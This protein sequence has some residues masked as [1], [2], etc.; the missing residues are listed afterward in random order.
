MIV[1]NG[2]TADGTDLVELVGNVPR[3]VL[4]CVRGLDEGPRVRGQDTTIPGLPG[5]I[6]RNRVADG[7]TIEGEGYVQGLGES[8]AEELADFRAIVEELR[9]LCDPTQDPYLLEVELEDGGVASIM[10]RPLPQQPLWGPGDQPTW[11]ALSI[12]WEAV[13]D[14]WAIDGAS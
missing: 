1:T 5:R 6:A 8:A 9:A 11:R 10:A 4:R 3:I 13:G 7:R 12:E 2:I 14:D